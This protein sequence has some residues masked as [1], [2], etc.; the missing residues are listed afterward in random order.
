MGG[1][2]ATLFCI[3][4][5]K[6]KRDIIGV[7]MSSPYFGNA[8]KVP[9]IMIALSGILAK[10]IPNVKLPA[11]DLTPN[12]TH[13]EEIY[14]RH[15]KDE[16]TGIRGTIPTIRFGS[17]LLKSQKRINKH[18][19]EWSHQLLIFIAGDDKLADV[20][21][22]KE[23]IAKIAPDLVTQVFYDYNYHENFNE[24]NRNET[25][26]TMED[27]MNKLLVNN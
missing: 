5:L 14:D 20:K 15:R 21:T 1:S 7:I 24:V 13:D 12:L 10:L 16:E 23:Q 25:F 27:W 2:I 4:K 8:V 9:G 18:I 22:T 19:H 3:E 26:S 17:E 6:D 11:E